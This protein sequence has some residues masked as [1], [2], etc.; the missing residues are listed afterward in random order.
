MKRSKFAKFRDDIIHMTRFKTPCR[1]LWQLCQFRSFFRIN[2]QWLSLALSSTKIW[3]GI[4]KKKQKYKIFNGLE[5]RHFC[6]SFLNFSVTKLFS[7]FRRKKKS[8][9]WIL[10]KSKKN[11]I[12]TVKNHNIYILYETDLF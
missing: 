9:G 1:F 10:L 12:Q 3:W 8:E 7:F 4:Q 5:D 6:Y 2:F 11:F